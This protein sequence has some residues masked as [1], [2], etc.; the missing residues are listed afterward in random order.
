MRE[1]T[2]LCYDGIPRNKSTTMF[3]GTVLKLFLDLDQKTF[4]KVRVSNF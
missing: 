4:A 1:I 2:L 3:V